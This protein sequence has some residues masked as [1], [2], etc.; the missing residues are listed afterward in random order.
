MFVLKKGVLNMSAS[1]RPRPGQGGAQHQLRSSRGSRCFPRFQSHTE[2]A[3]SLHPTLVASLQ[4]SPLRLD[5]E[6]PSFPQMQG[7]PF[8]DSPRREAASA[9]YAQTRLGQTS[10][11]A[12]GTWARPLPGSFW[13]TQITASQDSPEPSLVLTHCKEEG[14]KKPNRF[15]VKDH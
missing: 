8:L 3:T 5:R 10:S 6:Y 9:L 7:H 15:E 14:G 13:R 1:G 4:S 2:A 11:G 12:W